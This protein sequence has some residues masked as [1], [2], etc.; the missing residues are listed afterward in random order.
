MLPQL[1][2]QNVRVSL[3]KLQG[4]RDMLSLK[5]NGYL[6]DFSGSG[7][8]VSGFN[9]I[10]FQKDDFNTVVD[11]QTYQFSSQEDLDAFNA[12]VGQ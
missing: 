5:Y 12:Q 4:V 1:S 3:S 9:P 6:T 2:D 10:S 8:D 11:G 7:F